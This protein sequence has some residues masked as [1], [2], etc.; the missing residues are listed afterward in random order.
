MSAIL[1]G[2]GCTPSASNTS[3]KK[4][5]V[6]SLDLAFPEVE[7][8]AVCLCHSH[9]VVEILIVFSLGRSEDSDV[10]GDA[11]GSRA[12]FKYVAHTLLE[13][14]LAQVET[15]WHAF[16]AVATEWAIECRQ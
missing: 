11:D 4:R 10:V 7:Y 5:H 12:M 3:P 16:V 15:E 2:S 8:Q 6:C 13:Y 14:I 9:Q 1:C